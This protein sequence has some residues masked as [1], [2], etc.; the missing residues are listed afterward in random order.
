[1]RTVAPS[2]QAAD[3]ELRRRHRG[4]VERE[5]RV[6]ETVAEAE[7]GI[8]APRVVPAVADEHAFAVAHL[9]ALAGIARERGRVLDAHRNAWWAASPT[10]D[11]SPESTSASAWPHS[12]PANQHWTIAL[13][14][15]AQAMSTGDAVF[16]TTDRAVV[17]RG[18]RAHE[19]VLRRRQRHR[20]AVVA[21]GLPVAVGPDDAHHHV[22]ARRERDRPFEQIGR[23]RRRAPDRERTRS[24]GPRARTRPRARGARPRRARSCRS[25]RSSR[26]P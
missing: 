8:D 24:T 20:L 10:G 1:M 6:R 22:G 14:S 4:C 12:S 11:T 7:P 16:T 9:A 25:P 21:L 26:S 3:G 18:D 15:S 17:D 13:T 19:L 2:A 23:R 5:R